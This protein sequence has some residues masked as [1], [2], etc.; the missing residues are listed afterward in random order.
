MSISTLKMKMTLKKTNPDMKSRLFFGPDR[1]LKK[2]DDFRRVFDTRN[3]RADDR[4]IMYVRRSDLTHSRVGICVGK[5]MGNAVLRNR[6]KR[7]L[8]EAFRQL[9]HELPDGYD[10][11]L[12]PRKTPPISSKK[13]A[14]SLQRLAKRMEKQHKKGENG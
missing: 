12:I 11:V 14:E 3:S 1:R 9:Q 13:Y 5:K 6:Y 2:K 4:L 8:R 7:T 10:Y